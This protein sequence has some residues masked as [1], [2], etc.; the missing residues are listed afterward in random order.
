M[1]IAF[2][3][4]SG[5]YAP[6][7]LRELLHD[8]H[9]NLTVGLVVEGRK[10]PVGRRTHRWMDAQRRTAILV[11]ESLSDTARAGGVDV[12]QT[13]DVNA[14]LVARAVADR[15]CDALVC[16]GFD[17]LFTP[18]LLE[19]APL[20]INAHPSALPDLRG[21]APLFWLLR[22][23]AGSTAMTLHGLDTLEDHGPIYAQQPLVLP[24]RATGEAL[25]NVAGTLAGRMLAQL[26]TGAALGELVGTPQDHTQASRAP[27]P[28]P[29]DLYVEPQ[30]WACEHLV[31]FACAAPYFR[32]PWLRLGE[33]TFY[34]RA[35]VAAEPGAAIPGQY[36]L[37]GDSLAV[38]CKDGVAVLRI[39]TDSVDP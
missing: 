33:D 34:V 29:E 18:S 21:P 28:K 36:V 32:A 37:H 35:G 1:R 20:G 3:G 13:C 19:A 15:H 4:Q 11:T 24:P 2:F 25:Y 39:Q 38:Q 31:N 12:L 27:R 16:V 17:R 14:P 9:G 23:G 7:A 22:H 8:A 30:E 26:L 10:L 6:P 5:P